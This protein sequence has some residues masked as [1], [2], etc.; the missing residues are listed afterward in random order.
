MSTPVVA[1]MGDATVLQCIEL[2]L[3]KRVGSLVVVVGNKPIGIVTRQ[4]LFNRIITKGVS[5]T[6]TKAIDI[7]SSPV[8]IVK[9]HDKIDQTVKLM[10]QKGVAEVLIM[11][12]SRFMGL[13]TET[14][15]KVRLKVD[16]LSYMGILKRYLVDTLAYI[17]F[18]SGFTV[19]IQV[20]I[21]GISMEK[22]VQSSILGFIVTVLLSGLFGRFLDLCRN[23][24]KV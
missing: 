9:P 18:W 7:M 4:E 22:F 1:T 15:I 8:I 20:L 21:V 17:V 19:I 10:R 12:G 6:Q 3:E 14:D 5:L 13:L 16:P 2:M 11:E 23:K 24:F